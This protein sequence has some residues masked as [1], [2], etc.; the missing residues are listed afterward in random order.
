MFTAVGAKPTR[1]PRSGGH[2]SARGGRAPPRTHGGGG[3]RAEGRMPDPSG[4]GWALGAGRP[5]AGRMTRAGRPRTLPSLGAVAGRPA[6]GGLSSGT[7]A[8]LGMGLGGPGVAWHRRVPTCA[9][10][11]GVSD[12]GDTSRLPRATVRRSPRPWGIRVP[13]NGG[14]ASPDNGRGRARPGT[15]PGPYSGGTQPVSPGLPAPHEVDSQPARE[16][17]PRLIL[18]RTA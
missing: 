16:S 11:S 14:P 2:R 13:G 5:P 10:V 18:P 8:H 15:G 3:R 1:G 9:L 12:Q 7:G 17:P 4:P 6:A